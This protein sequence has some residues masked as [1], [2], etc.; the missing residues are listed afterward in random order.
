MKR[1]RFIIFGLALTLSLISS[2]IAASTTLT[3]ESRATTL[4]SSAQ[5]RTGWP[6]SLT[7]GI[8]P[9]EASKEISERFNPLM[10]HLEK[11]LEL[12]VKAYLGPDYVAVIL[13]LESKKLDLAYLGP[14]AYVQASRRGGATAFARE[15]TLKTGVGYHSII[16]ARADSGIKTLGQARGKSF[17]FVDPQSASGY[18][19][20]WLHLV[21]DLKVKPETYFKNVYFGGSHEANIESVIEGEVQV[22][23][24]ND[25]EIE[26]A[27]RDGEI[28]SAKDLNI[29]WKS[30]MIPTSPI[31]YRKE[32]PQSLQKALREAVLSFNDKKALERI[33]LKGFAPATDAQYDPIRK[34]EEA[35]KSLK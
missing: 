26:V 17:A 6:T 21:R 1:Q 14:L 22:A 16:V 13:G 18:L 30:E 8:I 7:F 35:K 12:K 24:T 25:R 32:L 23:A 19:L 2:I 9:A 4:V 28:K 34:L 10:K 31:A 11:K 27:I 29:L 33:G 20:P 15:N 5:D 3:T